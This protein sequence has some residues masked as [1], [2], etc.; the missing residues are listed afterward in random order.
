MKY[1]TRFRDLVNPES[2]KVFGKAYDTFIFHP[3][4]IHKG[5]YARTK[6]RDAIMVGFDCINK[7]EVNIEREKKK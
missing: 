6:H 4:V 1:G 7:L 5:N 2:V 3:T